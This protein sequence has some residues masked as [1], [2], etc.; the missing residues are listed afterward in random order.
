MVFVSL[1]SPSC[2]FPTLLQE[3]GISA[4]SGIQAARE[5]AQGTGNKGMEERVNRKETFLRPFDPSTLRQAQGNAGSGHRKRRS[6][7]S[8]FSTI[9]S[10]QLSRFRKKPPLFFLL[11]LPVVNILFKHKLCGFLF[12]SY[13][14]TESSLP[15]IL[16]L[17]PDSYWAIIRFR[18]RLE[19]DQKL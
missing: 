6:T 7:I 12:N 4:P 2:F 19:L 3:P 15:R 18:T 17:F 5:K 11:V 13:L 16:Y 8:T 14:L 10:L 9:S 1:C